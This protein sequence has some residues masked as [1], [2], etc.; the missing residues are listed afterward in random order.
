MIFPLKGLVI[1]LALLVVV[2]EKGTTED[3]MVGRHH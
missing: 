1:I 2:L 3:E